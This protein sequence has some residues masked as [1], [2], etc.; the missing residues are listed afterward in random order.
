MSWQD[1]YKKALI[2]VVARQ[3]V[4]VADKPSVYSYMHPTWQEIKKLIRDVGIDF[5]KTS[6][7]V[8]LSWEE[9]G[10]T[11]TDHDD[12]KYGVDVHLVLRDGSTHHMRYQI[13]MSSLIAQVLEV[14]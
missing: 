12:T 13:G 1:G 5:E 2:T 14:E 10:G 4:P 8:E 9:F 6:M 11:F 3:G 7:P